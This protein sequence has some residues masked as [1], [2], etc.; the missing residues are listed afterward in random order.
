MAQ[1]V[2]YL[3]QKGIKIVKIKKQPRNIIQRSV[4]AL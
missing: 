2:D 4:L 3:K 1:V